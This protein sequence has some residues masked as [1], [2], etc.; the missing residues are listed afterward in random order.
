[1]NKQASTAPALS[2]GIQ[3]LELLSTRGALSLEQIASETRYPKSSLLRVLDTLA[4]LELVVR[5]LDTRRYSATAIIVRHSTQ[6]E[7]FAN[8]IARKLEELAES[9]GNTTE[10]YAPV[11]TGMALLNRSQPSDGIV[12]VRA[13]IG[14]VRPWIGEMESVNALGRAFFHASKDISADNEYVSD[15]VLKKASAKRIAERIRSASN[16][17][18]AIDDIFNANGVRRMSAVVF[19]SN[20][21]SGIIALAEHSRPG[22]DRFRSKWFDQLKSAARDLS[23]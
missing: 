22:T 23:D 7:S 5:A 12:Q 13:K 11:E 18:T 21:P 8:R 6:D 9:T 2:R 19:R 15:G 16:E 17:R 14:F 1:M 20:R 3:V 10:W 4:G